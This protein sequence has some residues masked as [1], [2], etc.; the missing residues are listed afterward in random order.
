LVL[1]QGGEVII[2]SQKEIPKGRPILAIVE[3]EGKEL[4]KAKGP[5]QDEILQ[6]RRA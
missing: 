3:N 2:A 1:T 5:Y 4:E 6:E